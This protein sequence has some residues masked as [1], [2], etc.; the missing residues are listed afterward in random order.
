MD[1]STMKP[2]LSQVSRFPACKMVSTLVL[3]RLPV[4]V[5]PVAIT[6]R[7]G[8]LRRED[9]SSSTLAYACRSSCSMGAITRS[10]QRSSV[11]VRLMDAAIHTSGLNQWMA[12]QSSLSTFHRG[13]W[14]LIWHTSWV[15]T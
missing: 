12:Q 6:K 1:E 10:S 9:A 15:S 13:S 5:M 3:S 2:T 7:P 4:M 8:A 11:S 14:F